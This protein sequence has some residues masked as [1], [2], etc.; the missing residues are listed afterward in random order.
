MSSFPRR[1]YSNEVKKRQERSIEHKS[2]FCIVYST[3]IC[4]LHEAYEGLFYVPV[5]DETSINKSEAYDFLL[6]GST[7]MIY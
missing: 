2:F 6:R 5:Y 4:F 3:I 1:R 7:D